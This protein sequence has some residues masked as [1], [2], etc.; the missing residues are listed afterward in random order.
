MHVC[1]KSTP[2]PYIIGHAPD[3]ARTGDHADIVLAAVLD[4][5][6]RDTRPLPYGLV[7]PNAA[8]PGIAAVAHDPL[9]GLRSSDDHHSVDRSR[10]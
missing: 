8:N 7:H 1:P 2:S 10:D 4:R 3:W 9:C 6:R 5:L